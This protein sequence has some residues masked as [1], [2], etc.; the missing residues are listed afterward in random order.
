MIYL[1]LAD[2]DD[3][4]HKQRLSEMVHKNSYFLQS[5]EF[6]SPAARNLAISGYS[7][8]NQITFN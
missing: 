4:R 8:H 7:L 6:S 5:K 3:V 2:M 1:S